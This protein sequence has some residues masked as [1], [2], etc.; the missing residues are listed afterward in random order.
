MSS[1]LSIS[2]CNRALS[3]LGTLS[4]TL[5]SDCWLRRVHILSGFGVSMV[6]RLTCHDSSSY[7]MWSF[8]IA[9]ASDD[10]EYS[11]VV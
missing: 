8:T 5:L 9:L 4:C 6:R 10:L 7:H 2:F 11:R 1:S 3:P